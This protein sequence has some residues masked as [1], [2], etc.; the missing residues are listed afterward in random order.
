MNT[1]ID[2][3]VIFGLVSFFML[4]IGIILYF[5]KYTIERVFNI[6]LTELLTSDMKED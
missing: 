1:I 2:I 3:L 6:D 5:I 4:C